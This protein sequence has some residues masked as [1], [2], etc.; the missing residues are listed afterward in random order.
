VPIIGYS[1]GT[2]NVDIYWGAASGVSQTVA[3]GV[4]FGMLNPNVDATS[5]FAQTML[6]EN[7][8]TGLV[9]GNTNAL[10]KTSVSVTNST[11]FA[12]GKQL[13]VRIRRLAAGQANDLA[14]PA[15]LYRAVLSYT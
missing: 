11:G 13:W 6:A 4:A 15:Y 5:V 7:I 8:A 10:F 9:T 12:D 14:A 1:T 3:W 2:P